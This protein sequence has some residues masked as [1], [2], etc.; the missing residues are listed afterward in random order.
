M[1]L[2]YVKLMKNNYN[3][4]SNVS[5][6]NPFSRICVYQCRSALSFTSELRG[7]SAQKWL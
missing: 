5:Y 4:G 2:N 3:L 7:P 1:N 6:I